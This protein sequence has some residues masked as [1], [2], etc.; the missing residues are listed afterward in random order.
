MTALVLSTGGLFADESAKT[1]TESGTTEFKAGPLALSVTVQGDQ[2]GKATKIPYL[3]VVTS[4]LSPQLRAQINLPEGMG[5]SVDVVAKDSPAEKA[6]LKRYDVLK[7]FN[8]QMLCAQEQLAVLVKAAGK[9]AKVILVV[10]SGGKEQNMEVILGEHDAPE[11]GKALFSI[12]G[13]PGVSV[14]V[15]DL[16]RMLQQG[17]VENLLPEILKFSSG[18]NSGK[19]GS[20]GIQQNWEET[21]NKLERKRKDLEA[22][23]EVEIK[24]NQDPAK[25]GENQSSAQAQAFSIYPD[26]N[27]Q[28]MISVT[29]ADGTVEINQFNGKRT[30]KIKD[31]SGQE[32]YTGD[33]NNES[34]HNAVPEKFRAKVKDVAGKIK[35]GISSKIKGGTIRK[36]EREATPPTPDD[37]GR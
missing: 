37:A 11:V 5:L 13:T 36:F 20:A 8:D 35:S 26:I 18:G 2:N 12:N 19:S 31:S 27:A 4:P 23:M 14:Q 16:D 28:S 10:L 21:R 3:G 7:K 33:L 34:D 29:D 30:V 22:Q 1:D 25:A 6:G 9:G 24:K 15:Q 17:V 32:I